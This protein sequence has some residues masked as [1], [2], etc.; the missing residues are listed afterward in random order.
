[1]NTKYILGIISISI[2]TLW[3]LSNLTVIALP[4]ASTL[5]P[6][7][8]IA[9]GSWQLVASDYKNRTTPIILVTVGV[10]LGLI[11]LGFLSWDLIWQS[12]WP[13]ILIM[14]GFS[15][16]GSRNTKKMTDKN[17]IGD[18]FFNVATI[19]GSDKKYIPSQHFEGGDILTVFGDCSI[20]VSKA[21]V[22][23]KPAKISI[24]SLFGEVKVEVPD[25]WQV[26]NSTT[27]IFAD[28]I[29]RRSQSKGS[30]EDKTPDC[31]IEGVGI[32]SE[33]TLRN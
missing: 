17:T 10:L 7:G 9:L 26:S 4:T 19:F 18:N 31:I 32:F 25:S 2:G 3:L 24:F 23:D 5:I 21:K 16:L 13:V 8:L 20:D 11:Q 28:V 27:S 22:S 33:I 15:F 30:S 29:D 14:V 12:F 6:I 1:M